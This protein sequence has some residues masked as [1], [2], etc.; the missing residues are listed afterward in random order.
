MIKNMTNKEVRKQV[1]QKRK[2][3]T[4]EYKINSCEIITEKLLAS[5]EYQ[6]ADII[7][8]YADYNGEVMTDKIILN[9]LLKS[10]KV[11]APVCRDDYSLDF[12]RIY[13]LDEL[14][15]LHYGIREP[16]QIEY[17]QLKKEDITSNTICITPGTCFDKNNNRIGYGKGYYD[18]FFAENI[19]NTRIGL[20]YDFQIV[21]TLETNDTD[22]P[23]TIVIDDI[24]V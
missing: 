24:V 19:I 15:P 5:P 9:S 12:Y 1:I 2:A 7:L 23:M 16:L 13:S 11:Y 10:K 22:I 4:L 20:A 8:V 14:Y 21:D 3:L 18:R 6:N 17:E